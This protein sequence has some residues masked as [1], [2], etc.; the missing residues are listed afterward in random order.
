[1]AAILRSGKFLRIVS[2]L[3]R[4][5][6]EDRGQGPQGTSSPLVTTS[7]SGSIQQ[8]HSLS[9]Q[10]L[11]NA[12]PILSPEQEQVQKNED[13]KLN[14]LERR[15]S[16][17]LLE[18]YVDKQK[19][20]EAAKNFNVINQSHVGLNLVKELKEEKTE[21]E[22]V[23]LSQKSTES[24]VITQESTEKII[25]PIESHTKDEL[26]TQV[27]QPTS[28][29]IAETTNELDNEQPIIE[30]VEVVVQPNPTGEI[31]PI[32]A[33]V[34]TSETQ[35]TDELGAVGDVGALPT[36]LVPL[37]QDPISHEWYPLPVVCQMFRSQG[38]IY[39]L[40]ALLWGSQGIRPEDRKCIY[41]WTLQAYADCGMFPQAVDLTRRLENEGLGLEF[42]EYQ[43]LMNSFAMAM[44]SQ[45]KVHQNAN[46]ECH[47]LSPTP[48]SATS[49]SIEAEEQMALQAHFYR[50]LKK[51]ITNKDVDACVS[52]YRGLEKAG[53]KDLNVTESSTL[54]ELF[55]KADLAEDAVAVTER[56]LMREAY[57]LP[58]IFRF[59]LNR[60]AAQG[61]VEAMSR[62]GSYLTPK[63]KKEVSFDNRLCN[64]YLAAGRAED[65][66]QVLIIELDE[67]SSQGID[68]EK[69][70][71]LKDKFPRGGAMGLL[72]SNPALV[73]PYTEMALKFVNFGYVAP[74]NVLWTYHFINGRHDLAQPLW[75]QF[76]R[77]CPQIMFQKV[78]QT[79]RS[80]ANIDLA[81]RLVKLLEDAVVTNGARG[82]AYSC[83]LDVLTRNKDF[84]R[85]LSCVNEGLQS[86]I[87]LE[88]IN[89]TALKR[90]KEGVEAMGVDFP[91]QVPQK[92]STAS[93]IIN[94]NDDFMDEDH[95][96]I[97][98]ATPMLN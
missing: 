8:H 28:E 30:K 82:I 31:E 27:V 93:S 81:E 5:S 97:R 15:G 90:L 23:I 75:D 74:V 37:C 85:G 58:R 3:T 41:Y 96:S 53:G 22:Q 43:T 44:Y 86:G 57:P 36:Q 49:S 72:E 11:F 21:N 68:D 56:M 70:Q 60:L 9:L 20:E 61:Q 88:D 59:L 83:L 89:R 39:D 98:S 19:L 50:K 77:T 51:A 92:S 14:L 94:G 71:I 73:V 65:Y 32:E 33:D 47:E 40:E 24:S 79:A 18:F 13:S 66:L 7:Y 78:C 48:E 38:R 63:I 54:I 84:S 69:L 45:Q 35:V 25:Q 4:H 2:G 17:P 52:N 62:I 26:P 55:V 34:V 46:E 6:T 91:Y 42:P 67:A 1:M 16:D 76:V 95:S 29:S 12:L 87:L 80:T 10:H 64:G